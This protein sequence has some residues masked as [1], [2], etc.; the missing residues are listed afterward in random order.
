MKKFLLIAALFA[1]FVF[2]GE[3][4]LVTGFS[5]LEVG[6]TS[7]KLQ[8][9]LN[10]KGL[11]IFGVFEH[12]KLAK[13][14]GLQMS[15]TVVVAFGAPKAGTPL[16]QCEPSIALELPLKMV[17]YKNKDGKTVVAYDDI[18]NIAKR[19]DVNCDEV[20]AK[21]SAAQANFFKAITK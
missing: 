9:I 17:I 19:Y 16:M 8:N 3:K 6:E 1:S 18:K 10:E 13:E 20:I 15:D 14:A 5:P 2:G 21:L 4:M 12:S 11:K 7:T